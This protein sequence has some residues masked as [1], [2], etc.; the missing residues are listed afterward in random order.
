[1][2]S[3]PKILAPVDLGPIDPEPFPGAARYAGWLARQFHSE[4]TLLHVLDSSIFEPSARE[5]T[6][7]VIRNLFERWRNRTESLLANFLPGE[8]LNLDVQRVVLSGKP[9]DEIVRFAHF[10]HTSLIVLPTYTYEP[11]RPFGLGSVVSRILHDA[12]CPVLTGVHALDAF[13]NEPHNF[14]RVLCAVDFC[15]QGVKAVGWASQF[16]EQ[17]HAQLTIAHITPSTEGGVGEY[18]NPE[19]SQNW[20]TETRHEEFAKQARRQI[21]QMQERAGVCATVFIDSSIDVPQAVCSAASRLDADLVVVGRGPSTGEGRLHTKVYS[22]VRQS[23]C[24][25]VTL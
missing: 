1:M 11:F 18:F 19:R 14:G 3:L 20:A 10:E 6:D 15:P 7:P 2:L 12:D 24:P 22:I 5:F 17:F 23:P 16:A 21:E 8:F 4:L 25:V 9:A 13:P